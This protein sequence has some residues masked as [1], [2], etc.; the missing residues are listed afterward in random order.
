V[1]RHGD[2]ADAEAEDADVR[3]TRDALRLFGADPRLDSTALQTVGVKGWDGFA[4]AVV[5]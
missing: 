2:V 3:G 5:R 4:L 1:V